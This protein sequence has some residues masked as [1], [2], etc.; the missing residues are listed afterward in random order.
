MGLSWLK[1]HPVIERFWLQFPVRVHISV[2]SLILGL[3]AYRRQLINVSL[4]HQCSSP[5]LPLFLKQWKSFLRWRLKIVI[6]KHHLKWSLEALEEELSKMY[7]LL[8][9]AKPLGRRKIGIFWHGRVF[10]SHK[11]VISFKKRKEVPSLLQQQPANHCLQPMINRHNLELL[12]FSNK[13]LFKT[14]LPISS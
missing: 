12:F 9:P 2:V 14:I 7:G 10:F 13:L 6:I 1:C 11:N 8:Q 5:S 3:G 4:L